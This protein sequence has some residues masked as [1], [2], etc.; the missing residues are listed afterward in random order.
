[1]NII[2]KIYY[3][4]EFEISSAMAVGS[5]ENACSDQDIIK[6]SAGDPY[7]PGSTLAGI[8]RSLVGESDGIRYFGDE[9]KEGRIVRKSPDKEEKLRE[10]K[11][12]VYDA[13]LKGGRELQ[14]YRVSIRDCVGLDEWKTAKK[15]C[16]FDFEIVEPGAVFVTYLEQNCEP[17]D[18]DIGADLAALWKGNQFRIGH[19][20]MRGLGTVKC[21]T[22]CRREFYMKE[23]KNEKSQMDEWLDFDMYADEAW[24]ESEWKGDKKTGSMQDEYILHMKLKQKGGLSIRRYTTEISDK[25][26]QATPDY[27]Q[28]AYRRTGSDDVPFIP[29]TTWAGAFCHHMEK[30]IPGVTKEYFGICEKDEDSQKMVKKKSEIWF[31]ESEIENAKSKVLTRT[32]IDR[33]TGGVVRNALFTERICYGGELELEIGFPSNVPAAFL[34]AMAA[35]LVDL[36]MGILSAGGETSI[37]RGLFEIEKL[38]VNGEEVLVSEEMYDEILKKM[39]GTAYE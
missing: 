20:T 14:E 33:F 22:I 24:D 6:D 39:R 37:G 19:K 36:H 12:M 5:G 26:G 13:K 34:Q 16:K 17:G 35:S 38:S 8:Y 30:L 11:V 15:G 27:E 2:K 1:M 7:I 25:K 29:G 10:S 21:R 3:R 31:G 9:L 23:D 28:I 4:I 32:A 18:R